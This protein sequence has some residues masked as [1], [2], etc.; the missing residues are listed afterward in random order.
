MQYIRRRRQW[1]RRIKQS[2]WMDGRVQGTSDR[3]GGEALNPE[4]VNAAAD[5]HGLSAAFLLWLSAAFTGPKETAGASQQCGSGQVRLTLPEWRQVKAK[6]IQYS[7]YSWKGIKGQRDHSTHRGYTKVHTFRDN[8][9]SKKHRRQTQPPN[10]IFASPS[11]PHQPTLSVKSCLD[12]KRSGVPPPVL[13]PVNTMPQCLQ[14][15]TAQM[16]S[17]HPSNPHSSTAPSL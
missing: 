6:V 2:G 8:L 10:S 4:Q 5:R 17:M 9:N 11:P 15:A 3:G 12:K 14:C 1:R 7:V 16:G 13:H